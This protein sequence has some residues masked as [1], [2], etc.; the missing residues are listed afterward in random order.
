[1]RCVVVCVLLFAMCVSFVVVVC[2]LVSVV[3]YWCVLFVVVS[4]LLS[5]CCC[6]LL[7]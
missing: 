7:C 6:S 4:C 2:P 1:M 5:D 3:C